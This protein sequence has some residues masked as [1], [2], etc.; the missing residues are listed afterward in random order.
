M[1]W[2]M[3]KV[4]LS[5]VK[6]EGHGLTINGT[7]VPLSEILCDRCGEGVTGQIVVAITMSPPGRTIGYW[8]PDYGTVLDPGT[9]KVHDAMLGGSK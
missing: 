5:C 1:G 9:V 8:E 4:F 2:Q 7:F 3:R 6:P